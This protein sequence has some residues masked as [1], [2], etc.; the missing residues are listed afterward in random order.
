MKKAVYILLFLMISVAA[1]AVPNIDFMMND[2]K[3]KKAG[4]SS[5]IKASKGMKLRQGDQIKTG[6][7]SYANIDLDGN[8]IRIGQNSLVEIS[9]DVVDDEP[10]GFMS[11]LFGSA[12]LKMDKLKKSNKKYG[13]RTPTAVAAVRGTEF[14]I[15]TGHDG[16][17]VVQVVEGQVS[18]KGVRKEVRIGA[19]QQ[20]SVEMGKD[21]E[22]VTIISKQDWDKWLKDSEKRAEQNA[23]EILAGALKK[24][25][26]LDAEIK[27][28]EKRRD[29]L[30]V[31]KNKYSQKKEEA[32]KNGNNEE[33]R[34]FQKLELDAHRI[35]YGLNTKCYYKA[36]RIKLVRDLAKNIYSKSNKNNSVQKSYNGIVAIYKVYYEKYIKE[37][38]EERRNEKN[39]NDGNNSLGSCI[40][41]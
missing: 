28:M 9:V 16:K 34:K 39:N 17:T 25:R 31:Q 8:A 7:A 3:L 27:A 35:A 10:A 41:F 4:S 30:I 5:W 32:I 24:A 29:E 33:A 19:N 21:P 23:D 1:S 12:K 22:K 20:S 18:L 14:E 36:S 37:I 6:K 2:V 26:V 40:M 38:E 15:I 11:M 13:V